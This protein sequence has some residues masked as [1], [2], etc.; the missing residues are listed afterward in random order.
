MDDVKWKIYPAKPWRR[1]MEDGS[2]SKVGSPQPAV[3][4]KSVIFYKAFYIHQFLILLVLM[5][6]CFSIKGYSQS[7]DSLI[8]EALQ[9]N[10]QLKALEK[11][12]KSSEYRSESSGYLPPPALGIEFNQVPS[13][14]INIWD[15]SLSQSLSISQMFPL[16][17][18]LNAMENVEKKNTD[19]AKAEY[20]AYKLQLI[21]RIK[22]LY[23]DIW[24]MEHH[25]EL[26]DEIITLLEVV[27]KSTELQYQVNNAKYS[28][29]LLIQAEITS[30]KTEVVVLDRKA[31]SMI[32]EM[33]S[34]IGRKIDDEELAVQHNW[35]I[36]T[37]APDL[38][39]LETELIAENPSLIK[40]KEMIE[41]NQLEIEANNKELIPDLMIGGMLMRMPR[42]MLVTTK[43]D[44][45]MISGN[46]K[47]EIMYGLMA[48]VTLPF[49]P[50]SSGK[51]SAK[52][53]E[54]LTTITG[55]RYEKE[56]MQQELIAE[57]KAK[58]KLLQNS[59]NEVRLYSQEVIPLYKKVVEVQLTEFQ[60]N[61]ATINSLIETI[62]MLLMK[63]EALSEAE[64]EYQKIQA[65]IESI[66]GYK[67]Y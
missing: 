21:S 55:I 7:V 22:K 64:A 14:E 42:G 45:M 20:D 1:R 24:M 4:N 60:N 67:K 19:I 43:T 61:R 47:T 56:N 39:N 49:A 54:L 46:G 48:S 11:R 8:N 52:E 5:L 57:L 51:Y 12:I 36:D 17:G 41:M 29:L 35:Q 65:E 10:L 38:G 53:E 50:W 58:L 15:K 34:L 31:M 2:K 63:E 33:N 23:Y 62:Q 44:P 3:G 32:Y 13:N 59:L 25:S 27:Y 9:N 26:R 28:D 66:T 18:K 40:M 30:N 37:T 16:G 6:I